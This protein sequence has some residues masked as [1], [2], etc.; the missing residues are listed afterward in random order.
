MA[1][2]LDAQ[3]QH[4]VQRRDH[5]RST[6]DARQTRRDGQ[7]FSVPGSLGHD[8]VLGESVASVDAA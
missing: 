1:Y 8:R 4:N 3:V 6:S 2:D 7:V 5:C